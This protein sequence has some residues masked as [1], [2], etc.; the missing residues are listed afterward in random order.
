MTGVQTCALPILI[1]IDR[2][3]EM[4]I[5]IDGVT[6]AIDLGLE[7]FKANFASLRKLGKKRFPG[8]RFIDVDFVVIENKPTAAAA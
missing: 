6:V 4:K 7:S 2:V 1:G 3:L 5:L 8:H